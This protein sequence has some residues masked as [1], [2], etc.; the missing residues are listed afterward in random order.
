M[1]RIGRGWAG[2]PDGWA[3]DLRTVESLV[4]TLAPQLKAIGDAAA[5]ERVKQLKSTNVGITIN[6]SPQGST[7]VT[8]ES[9]W[10]RLRG[11]KKG[12]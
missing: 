8:K 10:D 5:K 12:P 3:K 4:D 7:S 9:M 11:K 6:V 2:S 1:W